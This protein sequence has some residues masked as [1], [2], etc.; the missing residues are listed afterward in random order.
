MLQHPPFQN[1]I[2]NNNKQELLVNPLQ[3]ARR[4]RRHRTSFRQL[5][6]KMAAGRA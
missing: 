5:Q 1:K 4:S 2:K 3:A 6:I